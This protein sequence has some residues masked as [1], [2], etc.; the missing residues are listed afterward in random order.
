MSFSG[1]LRP[2][3]VQ[4]WRVCAVFFWV[5][6]LLPWSGMPPQAGAQEIGCNCGAFAPYFFGFFLP[7]PVDAGV[8]PAEAVFKGVQIVHI[9]LSLV[10]LYYCRWLYHAHGS[11]RYTDLLL[12]ILS[13]L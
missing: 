4:L 8:E 1:G 11:G 3:R 6:P 5:F 10:C 13:Q 12:R 9:M 2:D 7:L